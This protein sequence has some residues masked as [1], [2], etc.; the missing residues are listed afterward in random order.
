LTQSSLS[1]KILSRNSENLCRAIYRK[2]GIPIR[3]AYDVYLEDVEGNRYLDFSAGGTTAV[4]YSHPKVIEAVV[5][6]AKTSLD[7]ADLAIGIVDLRNEL[8]EE[9][10]SLVPSKLA[11]GKIAFG[12]S[13]SDIV[14]KAIRVARFATSRPM[15]ISCFEA[16]HGASPGALSASPTLKEMGST[17]IARFFQLPGFLYMP[18][19]DSYRPWFGVGSDA[20]KASLAF[21]ERLLASVVS[22]ELVAGI[23]VEPILSYGG[24]I[25]PPDGYFQGLAEI[26]HRNGIPLISDEVL[27][28]IGKT[29]RMFA[30]EHWNVWPNMLCLGKALSGSVPLSLLLAEDDIAE[31]WRPEDEVGMS[32]GGH[33]IGCA[34]ALAILRIV[35]EEKLVQHAEKMGHYMIRRIQDLKEDLEIPGQVRGL[36]LLVGFDLVENEATKKPASQ[37]ASRV[38]ELARQNGLI[39]G[40]V[41]AGHNVLR[42]TPSLTI[43][44][45]H[46][47]T[48]AETIE[49]VFKDLRGQGL[50]QQAMSH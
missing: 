31:K 42:F 30:L 23:I 17:T 36:G 12:H 39:F 21:L 24:N 50:V 10:K 8:A 44:E 1:K 46:I 7:M 26:C 3:R 48:A 9:I 5:E 38:V 13:G 6:Q 37:L 18:F 32:K 49:R 41:G 47:D 19:P 34:M 20:G 22:P 35:R 43:R 14:E 27:T 33:L 15:I 28:G 40:I 11:Q 45:E 25:V 4:G 16:H 29:G 2:T